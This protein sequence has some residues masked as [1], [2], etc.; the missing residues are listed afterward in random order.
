MENFNRIEEKKKHN[1]RFLTSFKWMKERLNITQDE[2]AK[3]IGIN[4]PLISEYK[5][6]RK[7]VSLETME[8]LVR[9][10]KG[11][12]SLAYMQHLSDYMLLE[13][14]PDEEILEIEKR[15][16]NPDY[17]VMKRKGLNITATVPVPSS[18][19]EPI[20]S[21]ADSLI[22]RVSENTKALETL[23]KENASLCKDM[24]AMRAEIKQ[25]RADL[26]AA[27]HHPAIYNQEQEPLP[28]AAESSSNIK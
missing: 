16:E 21:W 15:R 22:Y 3:R 25:L 5:G 2:L 13:N 1:E 18:S 20:P 12:L 23:L 7:R 4:S 9:V 27:L 14:A 6:G 11:K 26:G 8:S 24:A 17:E 19:G 10:S 28:M